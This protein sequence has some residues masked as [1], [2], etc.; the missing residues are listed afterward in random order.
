MECKKT[1]LDYLDGYKN[2]N[3]STYNNE[4]YKEPSVPDI[5]KKSIQYS[6]KKSNKYINILLRITME[7]VIKKNIFFWKFF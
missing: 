1:T 3:I 6:D 2:R 7:E 5:S 4:G